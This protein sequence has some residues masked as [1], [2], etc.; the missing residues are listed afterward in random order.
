MDA[1]VRNY[2]CCVGGISTGHPQIS[3]FVQIRKKKPARFGRADLPT[4]NFGQVY[5]FFL[6]SVA[7]MLPSSFPAPAT[8]LSFVNTIYDFL[9]G[10]NFSH[11]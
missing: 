5:F 6:P 1:K 7:V 9:S 4:L 3:Q 2:G 11:L 10:C 8:A